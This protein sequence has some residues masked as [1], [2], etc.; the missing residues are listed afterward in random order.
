[1]S[2]SARFSGH[3][4]PALLTT[5]V[6]VTAIGCQPVGVNRQSYFH[7]AAFTGDGQYLEAAALS[8]GCA[9]VTLR[10]TRSDSI[11]LRSELYALPLGEIVLNGGAQARFR[12]DWAGAEDSDRYRISTYTSDTTILPARDTLELVGPV[13]ESSC[14]EAPCQFGGL[15]MDYAFTAPAAADDNP[16]GEAYVRFA[17]GG[18]VLEVA[19]ESKNDGCGCVVLENTGAEP[20]TLRASYQGT[21]R[22]SA[23][24]GAQG[25]LIYVGFDW[26]GPLDEDVYTLSAHSSD[27]PLLDVDALSNPTAEPTTRQLTASDYVRVIAVLSHLRCGPESAEPEFPLSV[28]SPVGEATA[29]AEQG[30]PTC[31]FA[32]YGMDQMR[33]EYAP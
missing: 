17:N 3:R 18:R 15:S 31:M 21:T 23:I 27:M 19:S 2:I 9:C 7:G 5:V 14:V 33:T 30:L 8:P 22:G 13:I 26:A 16:Q 6:L 12:F 24:S 11:R 10:N 1:M 25:D 20:Y 28:V 29:P 32:P 4:T